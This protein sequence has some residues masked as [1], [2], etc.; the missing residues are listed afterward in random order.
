MIDQAMHDN[1]YVYIKSH[2]YARS[3]PGAGE[4]KKRHIELH[5]STTSKDSKIAKERLEKTVIELSESIEKN[6]GR[7]ELPRRKQ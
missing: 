4:D 2:V 1:P 6:G 7:T 5:L 3:L